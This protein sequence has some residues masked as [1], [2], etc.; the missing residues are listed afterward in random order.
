VK[1]CSHGLSPAH[2]EHIDLVLT[3]SRSDGIRLDSE[4][5]LDLNLSDGLG[6]RGSHG[7]RRK[8]RRGEDEGVGGREEKG[9][10][11]GKG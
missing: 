8:F 5:A 4:V 6:R 11:R 10:R 3:K 9:K 2:L 7:E 1:F